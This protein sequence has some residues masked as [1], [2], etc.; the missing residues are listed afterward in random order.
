MDMAL[1]LLPPVAIKHVKKVEVKEMAKRR[2]RNAD[3]TFVAD[4]PATPQDEAWEEVPDVEA[5]PAP[6]SAK[7]FGYVAGRPANQQVI[8]EIPDPK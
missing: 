1:K 5:A 8:E 4:N 3:G 7:S 2:A 6:V